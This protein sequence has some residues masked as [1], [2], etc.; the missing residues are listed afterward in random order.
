MASC[1]WV[2]LTH[3]VYR[4]LGGPLAGESFVLG[5]KVDIN[6]NRISADEKTQN[7]DISS[8]QVA[9]LHCVPLPGIFI[10]KIIKT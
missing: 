2:V 8:V 10:L 3:Y 9:F 5:L 1:P 4:H 7:L 6:R